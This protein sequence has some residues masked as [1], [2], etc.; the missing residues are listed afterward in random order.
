MTYGHL[1]AD[2]LYTGISSGPNARY[3]VWEAFTFTFTL[4]MHVMRWH[5]LIHN[6]ES[7]DDSSKHAHI[8]YTVKIYTIYCLFVEFFCTEM[9]GLTSSGG[10]LVYLSSI[11]L[12]VQKIN[13]DETTWSDYKLAPFA[14]QLIYLLLFCDVQTLAV[15]MAISR[16][17][18]I[19]KSCY[20]LPVH[21][22]RRKSIIIIIAA[23][24]STCG[25]FIFALW[26]LSSFLSS[27]NLSRRRLDVYHTSAHG[28]A[29]VRV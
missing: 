27:P 1:Q 17:L 26:F 20:S 2:C 5:K 21:Y 11:S 4:W 12:R 13:V 29:L 24:R 10:F 14:A 16:F 25:H 19:H 28:V 3:R 9:V 23:L 18:H 22:K 6:F 15:F 7:P 8:I